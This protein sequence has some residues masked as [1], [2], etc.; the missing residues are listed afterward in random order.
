MFDQKMFFDDL[1]D[2]YKKS[3]EGFKSEITAFR[4]GKASPLLLEHVMVDY[5]GSKTPLGQAASITSPDARLLIV[6]PWDKSLLK[7]IENAIRNA[8]LGFNP[9][10]DGVAIK[11][12]VPALNEERRKDL[13]KQVHTLNEKFKVSLRNL[14][15]DAIEKLKTAKKDKAITEDD[16]KKFNDMVQKELDKYIKELDDVSA[17]KQSE[18]LEV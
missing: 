2:K 1:K 12:P 15:R 17:K 7:E 16:D 8:N 10:N 4:T 9:V 6:Q 5:Y 13:V 14:R 11:V 18:I 3:I